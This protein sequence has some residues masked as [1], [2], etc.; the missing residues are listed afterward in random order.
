MQQ[1]RVRLHGSGRIEH[2]GQYLVA[3]VQQSA[4]RFGDRFGLSDHRRHALAD[5]AHHIVEDVAVIGIDQV[6]LVRRRTVKPSRYVLPGEDRHHARQRCGAGSIDIDDPRVSVRRPQHFQVQQ[7]FDDNVHRVAC[8]SG[9]DAFVERVAQTC[10]AG[11]SGNVI[12][13]RTDAMNRIGHGSIAGAAAQIALECVRQIGKLRLVQRRCCHDHAGSAKPAL[14]PLRLKELLLHRVQ[15]AGLAEA[16]NGGDRAAGGAE[17]G[18]Q[19]GMDWLS[20]QPYRAGTAIAGVAALLDAQRA[21]LAQECA[22]A[23]AR[24]R[25]GDDHA[26]IDRVGGQAVDLAHAGAPSASSVRICS[27]K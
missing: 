23:L 4:G 25:C 12:L 1:W 17:G 19:T 10:A 15:V 5:E 21:L 9:D 24:P 20:V 11:L 26:A 16:L 14:E 18:H 2:R 27:A 3:H 6:I 22:Q 7:P 8:Q 13:D